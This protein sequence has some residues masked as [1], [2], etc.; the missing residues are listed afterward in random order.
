VAALRDELEAKRAH[1]E[2]RMQECER[3]SRDERS[4]LQQ[5]ISEMR[6]QLEAKK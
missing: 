6:R 4:Q 5:T 1:F 3:E 2:D